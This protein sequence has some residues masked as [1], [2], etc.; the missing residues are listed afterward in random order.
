[1]LLVTTSKIDSVAQFLTVLVL[2]VVVLGATW[3]TTRIIAGIQRGKL[4]GSN[5][6]IIDTFQLAQNKYIQIIKVGKRYLAIAVCKDSVTLLTELDE[7][8]LLLENADGALK[9]DS[10]DML[11]QKAKDLV[12]KDSE[13]ETVQDEDHES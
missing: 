1:M 6:E 5:F 11:F 4:K 10:F 13:K 8:E 12:K 9:K 7:D 2:F 3:F